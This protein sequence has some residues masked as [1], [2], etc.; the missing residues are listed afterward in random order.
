KTKPAVA[1]ISAST[2]RILDAFKGGA[3]LPYRD[4]VK[5]FNFL[6][7]CHVDRLWLAG[8]PSTQPFHLVAPYTRYAEQWLDSPWFDRY[9][10]SEY[11]I[12]T[13]DVA[14][15]SVR[16][17]S[18]GQLLADHRFQLEPKSLAPGGGLMSA[19]SEGLLVRRPVAVR[20]IHYIGKESNK[21]SDRR[22]G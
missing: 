17:K 22:L 10:G 9:S 2:P 19:S 1:R 12:T 11:A 5:P 18:Y 3:R 6:L 20:E 15:E 4:R 16:V 21:L 7:T 8:V 14:I 13:S